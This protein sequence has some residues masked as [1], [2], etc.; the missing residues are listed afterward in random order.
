MGRLRTASSI[1]AGIPSSVEGSES[2]SHRMSWQRVIRRKEKILR[3]HERDGVNSSQPKPRIERMSHN[4]DFPGRD[5]H[6]FDGLS[7]AIEH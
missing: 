6:L 5:S 2:H 7:S 1:P 3:F 4:A